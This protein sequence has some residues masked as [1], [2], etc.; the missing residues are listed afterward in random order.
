MTIRIRKRTNFEHGVEDEFCE[1]VRLVELLVDGRVE[2]VI[3]LIGGEASLGLTV[4][5][6]ENLALGEDCVAFVEPALYVSTPLY[7]FMCLF[8]YPSI[9]PAIYPLV[10]IFIYP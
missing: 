1:R 9:Y 6:A 2:L 3:A 5:A 8:I 10:P 7:L 4:E